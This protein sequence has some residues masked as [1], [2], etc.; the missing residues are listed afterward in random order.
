ML[1]GTIFGIMSGTGLPLVVLVYGFVLTEFIDF[2]IALQ[3]M[4]GNAI[5]DFCNT[6]DDTG[7][8][9]YLKS[10]DPVDMLEVEVPRYT[11]YTLGLAVMI[12]VSSSLSRLLWSVSAT[13]QSKKMRLDYFKSVL[14]KHVG[15][16]D[17]TSIELHSP[18]SE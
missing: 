16:F 3:V 4:T 11:Y 9:D 17:T 8:I 14:T 6:S 2:S 13:R 18:L 1:L 15:W 5:R 10:T 7:F 12:F